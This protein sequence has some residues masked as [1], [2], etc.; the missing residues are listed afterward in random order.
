MR[1][2]LAAAVA[3][4]AWTQGALRP[5]EF[6]Q[7]N[8][9]LTL[10]EALQAKLVHRC[11]QESYR[12]IP[13][14]ACSTTEKIWRSGISGYEMYGES[15]W[16][17]EAGLVAYDTAILRSGLPTVAAAFETKYGPP[18]SSENWKLQNGYGATYDQSATVWC[19][20]DGKLML[21]AYSAKNL[22]RSSIVFRAERFTDRKPPT[23]TVNF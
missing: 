1:A 3:M 2:L 21:Y 9:K 23:P 13:I 16:F 19:F 15:T 17:D 10:Q 4:L 14:Q 22:E 20:V 12:G 18:C 6:K 11:S 5:F 8:T 7:L